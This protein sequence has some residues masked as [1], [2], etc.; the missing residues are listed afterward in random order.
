[1]SNLVWLLLI[2]NN[3]RSCHF[4]KHRFI[5]ES[6]SADRLYIRVLTSELILILIINTA[7]VVILRW[8]C[9]GL[10]KC[11]KTR[12]NHKDQVRAVLLGWACI[13]VYLIKVVW[14]DY[15]MASHPEAIH[16]PSHGPC[17]VHNNYV[18][19]HTHTHTDTHT[20]IHTDTH[21]D[22]NTSCSSPKCLGDS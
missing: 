19:L 16:N 11:R 5:R 14:R 15:V 13:S 1:M 6:A 20:D 17:L 9:P 8:S 12:W 3:W 4:Q 22:T 10:S 21:T 18:I 7:T 2:R